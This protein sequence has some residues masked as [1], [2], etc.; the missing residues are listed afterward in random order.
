MGVFPRT[1]R[2]DT[3]SELV[4]DWMNRSWKGFFEIIDWNRVWAEKS[5][6]YRLEKQTSKTHI[7][8]C[9]SQQPPFTLTYSLLV[10]ARCSLRLSCFACCRQFCWLNS[11][12]T[13]WWTCSV[14]GH[15]RQKT[16][17]PALSTFGRP[18]DSRQQKKPMLFFRMWP[19]DQPQAI[20]IWPLDL[21]QASPVHCHPPMERPAEPY[22]PTV[23]RSTLPD[24]CSGDLEHTNTAAQLLWFLLWQVIW[25]P[26]PD[27]AS[28][29]PPRNP[30]TITTTGFSC[31]PILLAM[32][33]LVSGRLDEWLHE[34]RGLH[35]LITMVMWRSSLCRLSTDDTFNQWLARKALGSTTLV[36][37]SCIPLAIQQ[38]STMVSICSNVLDSLRDLNGHR[39]ISSARACPVSW[40]VDA[41]VDHG[42]RMWSMRRASAMWHRWTVSQSIMCPTW[43]MVPT[44]N[45][46]SPRCT[47]LRRPCKTRKS[48]KA[49]R[50]N[51]VPMLILIRC[52]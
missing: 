52:G 23:A 22:L 18:S 3:R 29:T 40:V 12:I 24:V 34:T 17:M 14:L 47:T 48:P 16:S 38:T 39:T 28:T 15:S 33:P 37:D 44:S 9:L 45:R 5:M 31:R 7:K 1:F 46:T 27:T 36:W 43:W 30:G 25:S 51:F 32:P 26:L 19:H 11:M 8:Q 21:K 13:W 49:K 41:A 42:C 10:P 2:K 20:S 50:L 35:L 6:T 4:S